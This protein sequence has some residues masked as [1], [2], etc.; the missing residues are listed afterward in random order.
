MSKRTYQENLE[1]KGLSK[2]DGSYDVATAVERAHEAFTLLSDEHRVIIQDMWGIKFVTQLERFGRY[3]DKQ[4]NLVQAPAIMF[5]DLTN[6]EEQEFRDHAREKY[7][8]GSPIDEVWHPHYQDEC[9]RMN[10]G[11]V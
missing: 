1:D 10:A 3:T 7:V 5:R 6:K 9:K 8:V 2:T 11:M 4:S